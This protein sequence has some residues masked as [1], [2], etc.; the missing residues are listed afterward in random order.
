[1]ASILLFGAYLLLIAVTAFGF[2]RIE[3]I[4]NDRKARSAKLCTS[5]VALDN[6]LHR[7]GLPVDDFHN[8][9][10]Q[11]GCSGG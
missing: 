7:E 2:W 3:G 11:F 1:M 10:R 9:I 5:L 4:Q 8:A 6:A